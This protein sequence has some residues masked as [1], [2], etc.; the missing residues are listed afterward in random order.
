MSASA[1]SKTITIKNLVSP[2]KFNRTLSL[3][4]ITVSSRVKAVHV[5]T[6]EETYE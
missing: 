6:Q 4:G 2:F 5:R 3:T 1:F